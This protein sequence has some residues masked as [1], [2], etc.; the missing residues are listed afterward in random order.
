MTLLYKCIINN[1]IIQNSN[2]IC[3]SSSCLFR[4]IH[5]SRR[6]CTWPSLRHYTTNTIKTKVVEN[7]TKNINKKRD[8]ELKKLFALAVPEK[9]RLASAVAFLL[10]SSSVTMVVPFCLGKIIDLIYSPDREKT[11]ENLNRVCL[12]LLGIFIIGAICN[13]SRIYLMSTSGHRITRSL[14][15]KV[16]SAIIRQETAMFD[17]VST[18]ELVGR[19]AGNLFFKLERKL[20]F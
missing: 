12:T 8:F 17:K 5:L 15:K 16:Y 3:L 9:W 4:S 10:V 19:L 1:T 18:G 6:K 2:R 11:K 7:T 13:F 14:R 20:C